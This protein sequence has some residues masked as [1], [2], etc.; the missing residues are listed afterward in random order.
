MNYLMMNQ[1]ENLK[2]RLLNSYLD[3]VL[4]FKLAHFQI[5]KSRHLHIKKKSPAKR[6]GISYF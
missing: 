4:I 1:F 3:K 5:C 6:P 2:M